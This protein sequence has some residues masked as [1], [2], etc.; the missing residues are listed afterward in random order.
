MPRMSSEK[1]I[2][3]GQAMVTRW[4]EAGADNDRSV[5]FVR[6]M[7]QRLKAGRY[8]TAR[9]RSWFDSA[10]T[11]D[12]PKPQNEELVNRLLECANTEGMEDGAKPLRDFAY[13][14]GRGWTLTERQTQFMNRLLAK[15]EDIKANGRWQPSEAD[16]ESIKLGVKLGRRLRYQYT[17]FPGLTNAIKRCEAWLSGQEENLHE[18]S[19]RKVMDAYKGDRAAMKDAADRWPVGSLVTVKRQPDEAALVIECPAVDSHGKPS[20]VVLVAGQQKEVPLT[21]IVKTRRRKKKG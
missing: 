11:T 7:I 15:A 9:Q 12:P 19:A 17:P 6:D 3:L 2:E 1:R 21:G 14:I 13:K 18:W 4:S 8:M 5:R 20:V 16:C 10:V